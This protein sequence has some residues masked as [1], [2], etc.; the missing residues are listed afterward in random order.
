MT[1]LKK[2]LLPQRIKVERK[3]GDRTQILVWYVSAITD[4]YVNKHI[5]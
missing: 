3:V 4:E 2:I 1:K 5:L